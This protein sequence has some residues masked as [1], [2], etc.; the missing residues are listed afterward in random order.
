MCTRDRNAEKI[1]QGWEFICLFLFL[2]TLVDW[3]PLVGAVTR[4][5][6]VRCV[7]KSS[8]IWLSATAPQSFITGGRWG[9]AGVGSSWRG[10]HRF[11]LGLDE[12]SKSPHPSSFRSSSCF[13]DG[14]KE[15]YLCAGSLHSSVSPELL[16]SSTDW[17]R[18]LTHYVDLLPKILNCKILIEVNEV[19][20]FT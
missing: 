7:T 1:E 18:G 9:R 11:L 5:V 3:M 17:S 20:A 19:A 15:V 2:F 13:S 14:R 16:G 10:S 8:V 4:S 12:R 6:Q